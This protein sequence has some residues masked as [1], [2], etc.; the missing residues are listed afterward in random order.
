MLS[1]AQ[2]QHCR[3]IDRLA[4]RT[5]QH[6][7]FF[8]AGVQEHISKAQLEPGRHTGAHATAGQHLPCGCVMSQSL[9]VAC[10]HLYLC[11][12]CD[13]LYWISLRYQFNAL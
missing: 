7:N 12:G 8:G 3:N 9:F 5:L 11:F 13:T 6:H 10:S 2:M 1:P 4:V